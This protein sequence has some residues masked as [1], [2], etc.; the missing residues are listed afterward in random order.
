MKTRSIYD[1][2]ARKHIA[3]A[4][5]NLKNDED[6]AAIFKILMKDPSNSYTQNSNGV[7]LNLTVTSDE[8]LKAVQRK[9]NKINRVQI[10]EIDV[11]VNV[12][13][14]SGRDNYHICKLSNFEKNILKQRKIGKLLDADTTSQH[15][16]TS[17]KKSSSKKKSS[18]SKKS[19]A[20]SS[21]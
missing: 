4:I 21:N 7:F 9:L 1:R 17:N 19:K 15:K 18:S 20:C 14:Q 10:N 6:Y 8:T 2:E 12:I 13:P 11:D 5:E 3:N 16:Y